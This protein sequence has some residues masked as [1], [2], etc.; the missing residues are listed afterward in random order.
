VQLAGSG[1]LTVTTGALQNQVGLVASNGALLV[2]ASGIDNQGGALSAV[3][4]ATLAFT[5]AVSN[6]GGN[7]DAGVDRKQHCL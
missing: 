5:G 2:Q 1:K 3:S 6:I 4:A 7:V